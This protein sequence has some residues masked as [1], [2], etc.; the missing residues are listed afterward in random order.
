MRNK[1]IVLAGL[2]A[3]LMANDLL[4]GTWTNYAVGDVML[5]LRKTA[6]GGS[7]L[8]VDLGNISALTNAAVN[9]RI[10]ITNYTG[11]Q[12]AVIGTNSI[13]WS[14][15][16]Y[17]DATAPSGI[18]YSLF[19]SE[20]RSPIYIQSSPI[21]AAS[22]NS[23]HYVY[24]FMVSVPVG[25]RYEYTNNYNALSTPWATFENDNGGVY[26]EQQGSSYSYSLINGGPGQGDAN[27]QD[28]FNAYPE[29]STAANFTTAGKVE[30][31][32]FYFVPPTT[33]GLNVAYL[34][35]FEFNT[36]GAMTYVAYPTAPTVST[37][38][39]TA[40]TGSGAQ[41]NATVA[42]PPN[43]ASILYFQ[44]GLTTSYGS[45]SATDN[46]GT[47][48]GSYGVSVSSLAAGTTYHFQ[49]VAYN[50]YGTNF[51]SDLTFTTSAGS[52]ATPVITG[53]IRTNGVTKVSFTTGNSGTY[54][55]YGSNNVVR[56]STSWPVIGSVS[57]NGS[58][59]TLTDTTAATN[60]FYFIYAQ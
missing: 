31:S 60:R 58:V 53:I 59:N 42:A 33:S 40:V 54:T 44:Y 16:A 39:A 41:L 1:K 29:N 49:A 4:A 28:T 19:S 37:L 46:I 21:A 15:S 57:G 13:S 47:T 23:Q 48:S 51:G 56:A 52:A 9:Q 3:V 2:L 24:N 11:S 18:Q 8:V 6:G 10:S 7:D 12:L 30:R 34:G 38:A 22:K 35:Y 32:D 43:D 25:A 26:P 55:L 5:C 45:T 27:W 17:L 20:P 36:N 14:A 50:D